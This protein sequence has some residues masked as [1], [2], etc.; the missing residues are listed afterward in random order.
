MRSIIFI[1]TLLVSVS[2]TPAAQIVHMLSTASLM[3]PRSRQGAVGGCEAGST[4]T[5]NDYTYKTTSTAANS[6]GTSDTFLPPN[7]SSIPCPFQANSTSNYL[8][9]IT[10][11]LSGPFTIAGTITGV[12]SS[13][14]GAGALNGRCDFTIFRW[15]GRRGGITNTIVADGGDS[16]AELGG[17]GSSCANTAV[18][19]STPT[20]TAVVA[21]DR[22]VI[23]PRLVGSTFAPNGTTRTATICYNGAAGGANELSATFTE[24]LTFSADSA[25]FTIEDIDA[26]EQVVPRFL[27]RVFDWG[28]LD[29]GRCV[30]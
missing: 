21:G 14:E 7:N 1:L 20:S 29:P 22:L 27:G 18:G 13:A 8:W 23:I 4:T 12:C 2:A 16:S 28:C 5:L 6:S 26:L 9:W 30:G 24:T 15:N 17:G 10:P 25:A 3:Q 19:N 11:P